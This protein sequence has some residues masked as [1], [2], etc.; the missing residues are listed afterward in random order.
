MEKNRFNHVLV[1]K[2]LQCSNS[3]DALRDMSLALRGENNELALKFA[4][5]AHEQRP[6]G[7]AIKNARSLILEDLYVR[8][9]LNKFFYIEGFNKTPLSGSAVDSLLPGLG[10]FDASDVG[11]LKVEVKRKIISLK[12]MLTSPYDEFMNLRYLKFFSERGRNITH[13]ISLGS[14]ES[15]SSSKIN[16]C[17]SLLRGVGHHS[18]KEKSPCYIVNFDKPVY[19]EWLE[20]GNRE[21][22]QGIRSRYLLVETESENG[23]CKVN[24][25]TTSQA[26]VNHIFSGL[27]NLLDD[28][29]LSLLEFFGDSKSRIDMPNNLV[30]LRH[31]VAALKIRYLEIDD[32]TWWCIL[33]CLDIWGKKNNHETRKIEREIISYYVARLYIKRYR[34][35]PKAF[36]KLFTSKSD[37][38]NLETLVNAHVISYTGDEVMLTKHG[39]AGKG[40]LVNNVGNCLKALNRIFNH[41]E[42]MGYQ[43]ILAYGT[44]LGAVRENAFLDHDDDIDIIFLGKA[45]NRNEAEQ[46]VEKVVK[47]FENLDGYRVGVGVNK[48]LNRHVIDKELGVMI[49]VFPAWQSEQLTY[50][51]MEKMGVR[52]IDSS[53]FEGVGQAHLYGHSFAAPSDS[54][55]FLAERYGEEWETPDKFHEWPWM[56]ED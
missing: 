2:I 33:Q 53:I 35:L 40:K 34:K 48:H 27:C 12:I 14:K 17:G 6:T 38:A 46:E 26:N 36:E 37:V 19:I 30:L 20:I 28:N 49:D 13:E 11:S 39:L 32:V 50:L 18:R 47:Y 54:R 41:F 16:D 21:D 43:P 15:C 22:Y 44:L 52:G 24:Y 3:T 5:F 9:G 10:F 42:K 45:V 25:A 4:S 56:L 1:S 23:L 7:P 55:Y 29:Y 51:H 31:I 8:E